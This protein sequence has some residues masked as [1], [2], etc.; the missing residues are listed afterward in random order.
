MRGKI[1]NQTHETQKK[2]LKRAAAL[3]YKPGEDDIPVLSAYGEGF[4]ADKIIEKAKGSGV[5]VLPDSDLA[6][7]LSQ[8]SIGDEI[9]PVLYE[10]VARVLIFVGDMDREYGKR[11]HEATKIKE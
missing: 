11:I 10:V 9:P 4:L 1:V 7:M 8:M 5:P 6:S 2:S 3:R